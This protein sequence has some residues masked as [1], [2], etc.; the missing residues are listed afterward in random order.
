MIA[1]ALGGTLQNSADG[2][3]ANIFEK[4]SERAFPLTLFV[5]SLLLGVAAGPVLGA[6]DTALGF[7]W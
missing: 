7:R 2:I 3:A 5:I 4:H 6:V 1:G